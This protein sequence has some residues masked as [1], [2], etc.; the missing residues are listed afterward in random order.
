MSRM[1]HVTVGDCMRAGLKPA[2]ALIVM[3]L[4]F[5]AVAAQVVETADFWIRYFNSPVSKNAS[6]F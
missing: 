2:L 4:G 5:E 3:G 1:A 6:P